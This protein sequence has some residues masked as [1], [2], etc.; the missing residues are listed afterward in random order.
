MI[1]CPD[2]LLLTANRYQL[3]YDAETIALVLAAY[4]EAYFEQLACNYTTYKGRLCLV[5]AQVKL[6]LNVDVVTSL[7]SFV[8]L[9]ACSI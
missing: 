9:T 5:A 7:S 8:V 1:H 3:N 6:D 2:T 4:Q